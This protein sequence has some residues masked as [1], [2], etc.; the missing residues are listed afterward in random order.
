MYPYLRYDA[1]K[2]SKNRNNSFN[3]ARRCHF[4]ND[5]KYGDK[6]TA[7]NNDCAEKEIIGELLC[8]ANEAVRGYNEGVSD[9]KQAQQT[10]RVINVHNQMMHLDIVLDLVLDGIGFRTHKTH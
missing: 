3:I 8:G 1:P 6:R 5:N 10:V 7:S 4:N 9:G 2:G